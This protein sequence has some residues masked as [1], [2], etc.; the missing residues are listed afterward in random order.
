ME[1][2]MKK[3]ESR[4]KIVNLATKRTLELSEGRPRLVDAPATL[5]L[6]LVAL[7]EIQEGKI[8]YKVKEVKP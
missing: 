5:K 3:V 4:Y 8:N 6:S 7:R 2:L 1:N